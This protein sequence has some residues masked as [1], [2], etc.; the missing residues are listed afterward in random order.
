MSHQ[1]KLNLAAL[2]ITPTSNLSDTLLQITTLIERAQRDLIGLDCI[3]LPE[4]TFGTFR[5]WTVMK[6]D[7]DKLVQQILQAMSKIACQYKIHIVAGT[8]PFQTKKKHWRNRSFLISASGDI[9][10]AYDKQHPFR[11]EK[12]VDLE[13]GTQTPIFQLGPFQMAILICSDL[14]FHNLVAKI[15]S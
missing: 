7:S 3:V 8:L 6:T 15:A 13:P 5:E 1:D 2:Q 4:Y 10:G 12:I 9:M 14:W 11:A